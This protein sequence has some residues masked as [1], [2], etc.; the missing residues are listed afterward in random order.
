VIVR[1]L[2]SVDVVDADGQ[3]RTVP[4]RRAQ[5]LLCRLLCDSERVVSTDALIDAVWVD[6]AVSEPSAALQTQVFR[7]RKLLAF[8]GAP[9]I[10]TVPPGYRLELGDAS[11]DVQELER[12]VDA[13][14]GADPAVAAKVLAAAL[15]MWRGP[16]YRG[17]EDVES[18]RAEQIR[19]DERHAHAI[20]LHC[21]AWAATGRE[22]EAIAQLTS[23]VAASPLRTQAC[24]MLMRTLA[25]VGRDADAIRVFQQHRHHLVEELGL[26]PSPGL[27][28]LEASIVR[29]DLVSADGLA[30]SRE[31]SHRPSGPSIDDLALN[32]LSRDAHRLAWAELGEGPPVLVVPAWISSLEAIVAGQDPRSA[33][34]EQL[35]HRHRVITYD[36]AG[37]GLSAGEVADFGVSAAV[38]E[39]EVMVEHLG[40]PVALVGVS[41][42]GPIALAFAA[43]RPE[44]VSHLALFG[45]YAS[46]PTTFGDVGRPIL[47][48]LR[49]RPSLGCELLAVLFRPGASAAATLQLASALRDA[50]PL[51]VAAGYLA[52][53]YATDVTHLLPQVRVPALVLHYRR[54]RV[55]PFSGGEALAARLPSVRFVPKDGAW[56]LPDSRDV[57]SIVAEMEELFNSAGAV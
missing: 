39:R 30:R 31:A 27:R 57:S 24:A 26:E 34:I 8:P 9:T 3:V 25:A 23:V 1:V 47:D 6:G 55:I 33:L 22:N 46:G 16:A 53:I 51:E 37:T 35:A 10:V 17:A 4:G 45:T 54:D 29:G 20:E 5:R 48:L 7:L 36:R 28:R 43:R 32:R 2:G 38:D 41:G 13:A 19:L 49:Q 44:F 42:A 12:A 50:A 15:A 18:L 21:A 11:T 56:H 14:T 52:A 40:R